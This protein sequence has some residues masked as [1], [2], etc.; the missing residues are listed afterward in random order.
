VSFRWVVDDDHPQG[1]LVQMTAAEETQLA[2][3][4]AA[5]AAA[6][7]DESAKAANAEGVR[8]ALQSRMAKLRQARNA[9]ASGAIF[10][11]LSANEKA[12]MDGLLEDNLYLARLTLNL[13]DGTA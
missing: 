8:N 7:T 12:V 10:A 2:A 5:W 6:A 11:G 4:R 13:Y 1:H 3:D 9:L